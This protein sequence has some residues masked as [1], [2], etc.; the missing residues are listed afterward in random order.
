MMLQGQTHP[1]VASPEV[2]PADIDA[3]K[4]TYESHFPPLENLQPAL[5]GVLA[6]TKA[7]GGS[8]IRARIASSVAYAGGCEEEVAHKIGVA[9][10]YFH[11]ASLLIDD[12]PAMDDG[13]MRRGQPCAHRQF[14]EAATLLGALA[15]INRGHSLI[16]EAVAEGSLKVPATLSNLLESCLGAAGICNGQALDLNFSPLDGAPGDVAEIAALKTGALFRLT[17]LLPAQLAN[18]VP[19]LQ[20]E[21]ETVAV[22][23]GHA[24]QLLDDVV[25]EFSTPKFSG[26]TTQQ[27]ATLNRP[28]MILAEGYVNAGVRLLNHLVL[29]RDALK[30]AHAIH[31]GIAPLFRFQ[32]KL[33]QRI[34]RS[35]S[36]PEAA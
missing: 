10:E 12:L 29:A 21:L 11:T 27:D 2:V 24:Y 23:W 13:L 28:N 22:H 8:L 5:A 32:E 7:H 19:M 20:Q 1:V 25:D 9:V 3:L 33:E 17:V 14:G 16:W 30:R 36:D 4:Q 15:L 34:F 18:M 31:S 35:V 6:Q 26:K